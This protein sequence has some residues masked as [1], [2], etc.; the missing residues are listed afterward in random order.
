MCIVVYI[1]CHVY[2]I[3]YTVYKIYIRYTDRIVQLW[4]HPPLGVSPAGP[5]GG[6][7]AGVGGGAG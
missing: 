2:I 5:Q 1:L 4:R 6:D 3:Q 7:A